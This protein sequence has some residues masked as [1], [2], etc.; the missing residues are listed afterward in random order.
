[1]QS[2]QREKIIMKNNFREMW[3]IIKYTNVSIM[4]VPEE[5]K[6]TGEKIK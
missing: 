3:D 4:R 1:M 2:E 5:R 6:G